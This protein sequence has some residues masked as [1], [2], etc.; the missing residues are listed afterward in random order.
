MEITNSERSR[1]ENIIWNS[2]GDYS[3]DSEIKAFDSSGRADLYFNYIIG[4]VHRY[5][6]YP[7]LQDYFDKLEL[8]AG[9]ELFEDLMWLGLENLAFLRGREERPVLSKLRR[10][11]AE[12]FLK[13]LDRR[14]LDAFAMDEGHSFYTVASVRVGHFR[15]AL[16]ETPELGGTAEKLLEKIEFTPDMDAEAVTARMDTVIKEFFDPGMSLSLLVKKHHPLPFL[17]LG[18]ESFLDSSMGLEFDFGERRRSAALEKLMKLPGRSAE[19][20]R[21]TV[22]G[23]YGDPTVGEAETAA[24]EKRLCIGVHNG[25]R[26]LFTAGRHGTKAPAFSDAARFRA[27]AESQ[28][29]ANLESYRRDIERNTLAVSRLTNL[30]KNALLISQDPPSHI[31]RSGLVDSVRAWRYKELNDSRIFVRRFNDNSEDL[32]VDIFLDSSASQKGREEAIS[33]Q[34]YIIAESFTRCR[35][36]VRVLTYCS[37]E[38]YTVLRVLRDYEDEH[39]NEAIFGYN[40]SGCNRDGLAVSAVMDMLSDG[41]GMHKIL[42]VLTDGMPNDTQG[43]RTG[44]KIRDYLGET[45]VND[46]ALAVRRGMRAGV[47]VLCVYTGRDSEI[48]DAKKIYGRELAYIRDRNRFA[49][50]VGILVRN[51]LRTYS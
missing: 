14:E 5:L 25:C 43:L 1:A 50:A 24:I 36:P 45:G 10:V 48:P 7:Q 2:A 28:R 20:R 33:T 9:K 35:V 13:N 6:D 21:R 42:I 31:A 17:Q 47:S 23:C 51:E 32:T 29:R 12:N 16:G 44:G 39:G 37:D 34:A 46:T 19:A 8:T 18:S 15:R 38:E 22:I 49:D 4:A 41:S 3:F 30:L 40:A 27:A 26:L 11:Y